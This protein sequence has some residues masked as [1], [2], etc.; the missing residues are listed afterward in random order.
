[1][2]I[3]QKGGRTLTRTNPLLLLPPRL[4]TMTATQLHSYY[5]PGHVFLS[6]TNFLRGPRV[7]YQA[8]G[9]MRNGQ[10]RQAGR[11]F[12]LESPNIRDRN[13]SSSMDL[14]QCS[15]SRQGRTESF[16]RGPFWTRPWHYGGPGPFNAFLSHCCIPRES[17]RGPGDS[18]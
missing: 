7:S 5:K 8:R 14:C 1:M 10:L 11:F 18:R 17:N 6:T 16:S 13:T 2:T 9:Q 3:K 15:I 4:F 12:M